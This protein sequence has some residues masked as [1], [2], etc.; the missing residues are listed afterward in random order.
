MVTVRQCMV[1]GAGAGRFVFWKYCNDYALIA[2]L[3]C[4]SCFSFVVNL[5][6]QVAQ[7]LLHAWLQPLAPLL[8]GSKLP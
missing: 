1:L 3:L 2:D 5:P 6:V 4:I 8:F 7:F